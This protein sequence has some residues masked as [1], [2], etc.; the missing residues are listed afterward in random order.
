[1][2]T[3]C[4]LSGAKLPD[5]GPI[6]G[7]SFL[8]RLLG[9]D[10]TPREWVFSQLGQKKLV[11]DTRFLLHED[12]RLYDIEADPFETK[13]LS[14]AGNAEADAARKRLQAVLDRLK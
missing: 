13:D 11:R 7:R 9:K 12:G 6:D 10:F 5:K 3:L 8:P 14:K 1:M 2:P 4:E